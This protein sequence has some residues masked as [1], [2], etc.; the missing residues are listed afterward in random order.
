KY[1]NFD[2]FEYIFRK[3]D[4]HKRYILLLNHKNLIL[5]ILDK[6]NKYAVI[7]YNNYRKIIKYNDEYLVVYFNKIWN[8]KRLFFLGLND[9]DNL[10]YLL[11]KDIINLIFTYFK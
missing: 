7:K 2:I 5:N 11:N 3:H 1:V 10:L 9:P 6:K 4:F 8:I